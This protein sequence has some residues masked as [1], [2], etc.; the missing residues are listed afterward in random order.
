M[1][2]AHRMLWAGCLVTVWAGCWS[3]CGQHAGDRVLK[4]MWTA[5]S[6]QCV[7]H[8][9]DSMGGV[10]LMAGPVSQEQ[11]GLCAGCS[12]LVTAPVLCT[13]WEAFWTQYQRVPMMA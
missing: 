3:Q 8:A 12:V 7:Q 11:Q 2:A 10:L 5:C 1:M 6:R 4:T 13:V 9:G